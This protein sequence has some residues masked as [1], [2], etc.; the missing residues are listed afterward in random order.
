MKLQKKYL[1]VFY[2]SLEGTQGVLSLKDGRIR[3]AYFKELTEKLKTFEED[4]TKVYTH[5]CRKNEDGTPFI[6]KDMYYFD[7]DT[8]KVTEEVNVLLSEEVDLPDT[9]EI[10]GIV[11][12][13]TYKPKIG[14]AEL[15]DEIISKL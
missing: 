9:P 14:E 15:I 4:R 11:E 8:D 13:T 7:K 1:E 2:R 3:D 10:K 5:Y 6:E 12:Q